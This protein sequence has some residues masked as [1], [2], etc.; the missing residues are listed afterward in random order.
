ML[1]NLEDVQAKKLIYDYRALNQ[2]CAH[3]NFDVPPD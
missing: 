3:S 2:S 1:V